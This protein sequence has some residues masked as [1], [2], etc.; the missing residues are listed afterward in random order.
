MKYL[1]TQLA[2]L[3]TSVIF[4]YFFSTLSDFVPFEDDGDLDWYAVTAVF[5]TLFL[6][7]QS[8]IAIIIFLVQKFL[9]YGWKE[10]P[11]RWLSLKWGIGLSIGILIILILHITHVL[12]FGWGVLILLIISIIIIVI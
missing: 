5:A 6:F 11:S 7:L 10:F 12:V 9:A 1:L 3:V 2:I 4:L 8:L